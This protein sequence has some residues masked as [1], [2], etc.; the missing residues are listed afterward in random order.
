MS[1]LRDNFSRLA[2]ECVTERERRER[3]IVERKEKA[4]KL[5]TNTF[6]Y[7]CMFPC[8]CMHA[9]VNLYECVWMYICMCASVC[10]GGGQGGHLRNMIACFDSKERKVRGSIIPPGT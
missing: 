7:A 10:V 5:Y 2:L 9:Y 6:M 8:V 1:M 4:E 3:K